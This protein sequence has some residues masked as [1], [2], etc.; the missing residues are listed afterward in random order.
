MFSFGLSSVTSKVFVDDFEHVFDCWEIYKITTIV[1]LILCCSNFP[2]QQIFT[3]RQWQKP[4][5]KMWHLLKANSRDCVSLLT[6]CNMS[7]TLF[8][9]F[10]GVLWTC[11]CL[12]WCLYFYNFFLMSLLAILSRFHSLI[13]FFCYQ[14]YTYIK[15]LARMG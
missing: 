13:Y 15:S 14:L 10:S 8:K 5:N 6:T 4:E 3:Q 1:V 11:L 2:S 12:L 7:K 9:C